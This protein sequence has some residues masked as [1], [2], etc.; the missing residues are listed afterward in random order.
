MLKGIKQSDKELL[1]VI[2]DYGCLFLCF[3]EVSPLIFKG[4]N[5]IKDLNKIWIQAEKKKYIS[6]VIN[7]DGDYYDS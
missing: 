6:F 2:Q 5:G 7:H 1:P 3:A 4:S